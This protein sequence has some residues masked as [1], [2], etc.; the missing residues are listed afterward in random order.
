LDAAAAVRLPLE[1]LE[2]HEPSLARLYE[3]R[4][5]LVR[6]DQHVAWRGD[7]VPAQCA[8]I[9]DTVRGAA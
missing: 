3:K 5:V 6:P 8:W 2:L 4:F 1:V 7:A 9:V